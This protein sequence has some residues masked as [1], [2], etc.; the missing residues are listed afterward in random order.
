MRFPE[1][2]DAP[3]LQAILEAP[4]PVA[5]VR[6]PRPS[7]PPE[8]A[9]P[10][11]ALVEHA[12]AK[13]NEEQAYYRHLAKQGKKP[14]HARRDRRP[15]WAATVR[16]AEIYARQ[17]VPPGVRWRGDAWG[18]LLA[19]AQ[20]LMANENQFDALIRLA[21]VVRMPPAEAVELLDE[22]AAVRAAREV[23]RRE[24]RAEHLRAELRTLE[25]GSAPDGPLPD[26]VVLFPVAR[27]A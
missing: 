11:R 19:R 6:A 22:R 7:P 23:A 4:P 15:L 8:D 26:N 9:N 14:H 21:L 12:L 20:H 10:F 27:S 1:F 3:E 16:L 13:L 24:M 2:S 5:P 25:E 17:P 18:W